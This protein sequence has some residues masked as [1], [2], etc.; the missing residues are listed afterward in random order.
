MLAIFL[1]LGPL[2]A[3]SKLLTLFPCHLFFVCDL[4]YFKPLVQYFWKIIRSM[5]RHILDAS[6]VL[7]NDT[8]PKGILRVIVNSTAVLKA[9]STS[10]K[11]E[12]YYKAACHVMPHVSINTIEINHL[13]QKRCPNLLEHLVGWKY[14]W[15]TSMS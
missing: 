2:A 14:V 10:Q 6:C 1:Q 3:R 9:I 11:S 4:A 7:R 13:E 5:C 15:V 12:N 8:S